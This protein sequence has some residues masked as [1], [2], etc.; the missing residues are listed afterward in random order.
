MNEKRFKEL[1]E[2]V[3]NFKNNPYHPL[4][5]INGDPILGDNVAIG[6]FSEINAKGAQVVIGNNC[7]IASFVSINCADS[8]KKCIGLSHR[9]YLLPMT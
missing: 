7:D 6:G 4:V 2:K 5:W 1:L 9:I 8:H 3:T